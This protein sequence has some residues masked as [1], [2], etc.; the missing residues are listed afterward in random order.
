MRRAEGACP[1]GIPAIPLYSSAPPAAPAAGTPPRIFAPGRCRRRD[2]RPPRS[3]RTGW[4]P[5]FCRIAAHTRG[6]AQV[7]FQPRRA[8]GRFE[9]GRRNAADAPRRHLPFALAARAVQRVGDQKAEQGVAQKF[10]P[11][12]ALAAVLARIGCVRETRFQKALI[13]ERIADF[14]FDFGKNVS[15]RHRFPRRPPPPNRRLRAVF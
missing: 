4:K 2:K 15:V 6:N 14:L 10:Q 9:R 7:F 8:H 13:A 1:A 12:V 5:P 11:L 3:P